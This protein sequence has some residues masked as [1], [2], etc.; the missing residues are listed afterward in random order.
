MLKKRSKAISILV[1][2]AFLFTMILPG[3]AFGADPVKITHTTKQGIEADSDTA[4]NLGFV[5]L[6]E[7]ED[8]D[9]VYV[10]VDLPAD[11]DWETAIADGTINNFID[12]YNAAGVAQNAGTLVDGDSDEYV[13]KFDSLNADDYIKLVFNNILV[14]KAAANDINATVTVKGV[15]GGLKVWEYTEDCLI[16]V[17]GDSEA[18]FAADA[19]KSITVG[20]GQALADI[21]F[22]ENLAGA[23]QAGDTIVITLPDDVEFDSVSIDD[24]KYGLAASAAVTAADEATITI[25]SVSSIFA[26]EIEFSAEV[27]V[28]PN[29]AEGDIEVSVEGNVTPDFEDGD[30]VVAYIGTTAAEF[31]VEDTADDTIYQASY[32]KEIDRIEMT[33]SG[34]FAAGDQ[35]TLS[36][37]DGLAWYEDEASF[38]GL[39]PNVEVLGFY[40]DNQS[41]WLE[42]TADVDEIDFEGLAIAALPDAPVGDITVSVSGDYDGE[43]VVGEVVAVAEVTADAP[44]VTLSSL[45]AAA[46]DIRMVEAKKATFG[47]GELVLSLPTGVTFAGKPTVEVNGDE[48]SD[49]ALNSNENEATITFAA[50]DFRSNKVDT[51]VISDVEYD[52]DTRVRTADIEVEMSGSLINLLNGAGDDIV[53]DLE[54]DYADD[55]VITVVNAAAKAAGSNDA[56]FVIGSSTYSLNGIE[57]TIDVAPYIKGDRTYMPLRYVAYAL[58][59]SESNILW[60]GNAQTVTLMK[61]DKVVQV[62]IGSQTMMINGASVT[63]DVAPEITSDRTM[64]PIRFVAQAFGAQVGWDAATQTVTIEM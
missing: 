37:S 27:T 16:G 53:S 3:L 57:Y 34:S 40:N 6:S 12:V 42:V 22:S 50:S 47:A 20:S 23:L 30:L 5:K 35:L 48:I 52:M 31:A 43:A 63:M 15:E 60:D 55:A 44:V 10:E 14:K 19:A 56:Q 18:T 58:G 59:V 32:D 62:K 46:G 1:S 64:L 41:V 38:E 33:A 4:Q 26:D 21:T 11:V 7:I 29:A 2:L 45:G 9:S 49:V 13:V 61:G 25:D 54:A 39:V 51:I 28:F 17:Q 24:G 8:A 36:L